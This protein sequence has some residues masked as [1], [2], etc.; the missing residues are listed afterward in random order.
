VVLDAMKQDIGILRV[1]RGLVVLLAIA[2]PGTAF[3]GPPQTRRGFWWSFGLGCGS[4]H[5][6]CDQC[7]PG[8]REGSFAGWLRLGG[9]IGDHLLLGWE[10]SG[11]LK[12]D[13]GRLETSDD[14]VRTLG[15]SAVIVV[16]YPRASSGF[17][18]R[19]GAGLA[20]AGLPPRPTSFCPP[21]DLS[22]LGDSDEGAHGNGFGM[23]AGAG[24][25]FRVSTN[26]SIAA[27]FTLTLGRPGDLRAKGRPPAVTG[28][29]HDILA[30]GVGVTF[31]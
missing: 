3:A 12:N 6:E 7:A 20:Y 18:M 10:A 4:A 29:R 22:C 25:D 17:S 5:I 9:T 14:L 28:W 2:S 15:N 23:T 19:V 11:W 16:F 13:K 21:L 30:F 26:V 31:H 24:Y 27:D 1:T 8:D